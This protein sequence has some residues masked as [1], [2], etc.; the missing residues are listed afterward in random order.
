[1]DIAGSETEDLLPMPLVDTTEQIA[2]HDAL[3][4]EW[5]ASLS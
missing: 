4:A 1:L 3:T 2:R 5:L